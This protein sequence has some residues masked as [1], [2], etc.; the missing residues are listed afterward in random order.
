MANRA[1]R[2]QRRFK[3][4]KFREQAIEARSHLAGIELE[5]D[6]GKVFV[7]PHPLMVDDDTQERIE[8]FQRG[9]GLDRETIVK[10]GE[11]VLDEVG[12]PMT[13]IVEPHQIDGVIL[14]SPA[15]RSAQAILGE[16]GHAEFI[17]AGGHSNDITLAWQMMVE[18]QK[19]RNDKDPKLSIV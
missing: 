18:E 9:D 1:E 10:D 13:R 6:D 17:A 11:P 15:I 2:R 19:E 14:P 8:Q 12:K 5:T 7:I 3:L 4:D 16:E